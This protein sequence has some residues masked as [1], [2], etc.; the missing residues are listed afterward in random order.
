MRRLLPWVPPSLR[1]LSLNKGSRRSGLGFRSLRLG[2]VSFSI[3]IGS[4]RAVALASGPPS[5]RRS[6]PWVPPSLRIPSLNEESRRSGLGFCSL[7]L[8]SCLCLASGPS[9]M[10]RSSPWVPPSLRL[11]SHNKD[12]RRSGLGFCSLRLGSCLCFVVCSS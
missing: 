11:L 10:R 9:S 3:P 5:M 6:S 7:R 8:G 1:L 4:G 2:S 12:S